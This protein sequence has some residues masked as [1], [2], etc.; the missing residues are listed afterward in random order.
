MKS[1]RNLSF[2]VLRIIACFGVIL[3]HASARLWYYLP[4]SSGGWFAANC[5]NVFT[6][7]SVPLFVMISGALFLDPKRSV[8]VHRLW[9]KQILRIG[10]IYMLWMCAYALLAFIQYPASEQTV[11]K[12]LKGI[13]IGRYHLWF[14]PMIMGLY[15]LVPVLRSWLSHAEKKNV[16]YFLVLFFIF[17]ILRV[18]F[19]SFFVTTELLSFL[20]NFEWQAI[21]GYPGYFLLGYYLFHLGIS[22]KYNRILVYG[23]PFFYLGNI[24]VSTLQTYARGQAQSSFT[25][26]FGLFT[27]LTAVGVFQ[28]FVQR[29]LF[30]KASRI[31]Q[32]MLQIMSKSTLGI[33][34]MHLMVME[35]PWIS[36]L[37]DLRPALL[38]I[39]LVSLITFLI[40]L[41][42]STL[43]RSI[44]LL[45]KYLC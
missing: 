12:L 5:A 37:F 39:L 21:C 27:F 11:S 45:G 33:Y 23:L 25:D 18:S 38:A 9:K 10:V 14:L 32:S 20:D 22:K 36:P 1:E 30:S 40:S 41:V 2:D 24:I 26:S 8:D 6:R 42:L 29:K 16:L 28:L 17:Q 7:I 19:K 13:L 35:S 3:L 34:L 31:F 15:A 44:P 43:L 4:I